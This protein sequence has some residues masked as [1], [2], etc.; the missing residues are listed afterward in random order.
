MNKE[1]EKHTVYLIIIFALFLFC[2]PELE[3]GDWVVVDTGQDKCYGNNGALSSFP[4]QGAAFYGQDAQYTGTQFSYTDNGDGTITDNN[5]G[6]IWI[7]EPQGK[8][9]WYDAIS[10]VPSFSLAG[11]SDWRV[12]TIKELYSLINFNGVTG[13]TETNSTPYL[14]TTYFNFYYGDT[15]LGERII[16]CQYISSTSYVSTTMNGNAT[17]FGV[18]FADGRIKGYGKSQRFYVRYVRGGSGYGENNF[19][20]NGDGTITDQANGLMWMQNDSGHLNAGDNNDGKMNWQ[21][22]LNWAENLEYGGHSDWRLP[23][24]KELQALVDYTRSPATTNSP[25]IDPIFKSTSIIDGFG[26]VNYGYFWTSTSHLDGAKL[27][28]AAVYVAFGEAQG[29]MQFGQGGYTLMDVHGAGAQ[30]SDPKTGDP[31]DYPYGRGP[32]GDVIYIYNF[33]R[34]VRTVTDSGGGGGEGGNGSAEIQLNRQ[35]LNYGALSNGKKSDSQTLYISNRG[36]G[37]LSWTAYTDV[38]WLNLSPGSGTGSG[39]IQV[40]L[41]ASGLPVGTYSG[42]ITISDPGATNS[43]QS[44]SVNLKIANSGSP[45]F[46]IY[47]TP[48]NG[49]V[50][51]SSVPFTGWVLDDIGVDSVKLYR[52]SGQSLIYIGDASLVE[53]ARPDVEQAYP[54]YPNCSQAG[55]G[56]MMLT[57]F[58]PN[59]GNGTFTIHAIATDEEGQQTTLGTRTITVDNANATKPFGAIDTPAQG[60]TASGNDYLVWGWAL[61]PTP[62]SIPTDGSTIDVWV[63][64]VNKGHPTYNVYR[65]DIA[66][67]FSGYHNSN[68]AVG[69][70]SLDAS[71]YEDG[72]YTIQWTVSDSGNNR[73]G[74]GSRYFSI[75]NGSATRKTMR[76]SSS[77]HAAAINRTTFS[78]MLDLKAAPISTIHMRRG[79]DVE[80]SDE[81]IKSHVNGVFTINITQLQRLEI[82]LVGKSQTGLTLLHGFMVV[83]D[84]LKSLPI[85]TTLNKEYGK[86]LWQP[87]V[88][89]QGVYS[90]IFI[91]EDSIGKMHRAIVKVNIF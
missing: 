62:S 43:P 91:L 32:Q 48:E 12:P 33:V 46:G 24:A 27:G 44:V 59:G 66:S 14:D 34:C 21:Q 45:C 17:F 31:S 63:N 86:F 35:R 68:G 74:I 65:S 70:F 51:S 76:V 56:Y 6:L 85:G 80:E 58:L 52:E 36:E 57:N 10:N 78:Q 22:A 67:L 9:T 55:W 25:A 23:N 90:F 50:V 29:F 49:A 72:V 69:Y 73:D 30:R 77:S 20:N 60:G 84:K 81:P 71:T 87:G 28:E 13:Q 37:Q 26:A 11:Y 16:D 88:G 40:S 2:G 1:Y 8:M 4:S 38:S 54:E 15:S 42:T 19:V 89:F 3:A 75:R 64:G 41:S 5:T 82:D 53:G 47:A 39:A 18:N 61:T 83:G 79:F 7:K